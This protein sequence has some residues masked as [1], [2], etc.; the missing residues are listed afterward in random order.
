MAPS[1]VNAERI[2]AVISFCFG[3]CGVYEDIIQRCLS[4]V[5]LDGLRTIESSSSGYSNN[6][7][8]LGVARAEEVNRDG[9]KF[10]VDETVE[11]GEESHANDKVSHHT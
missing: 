2:D 7:E 6:G 11:E 8:V 3:Y 10:V 4:E 1:G 5:S 9:E